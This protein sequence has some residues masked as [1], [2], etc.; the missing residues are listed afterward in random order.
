MAMGASSSLGAQLGQ[1]VR[2]SHILLILPFEN[3][4]SAPG[5]DWIGESFPEVIGNRM[6]A[7]PLFVISRD[8]RLYAFDRLGIPIGAKPSR[9]T[10]YE[11]AQQMDADYVVMG[12]YNFDGSTFSAHAQVMDMGKLRMS[13]ALS[14][15]GKLTDLI[16]IQ[17]ALTWDVLHSVG[18]AESI[19]RDE[20]QAQF[21]PI[22]L[23]ALE[24]YIRGVVAPN[25]QER[26][27]H[28]KEAIRLEPGH[29]LAMLQLGKTYYNARDYEQAVTWFSKVPQNDR[30]ANE[31]QFYLG[32]AA[33][34]TGQYEK[35]ESA[36]RFLTR[37]LPLTEVYNNLGVVAALRGDKHART[38]FERSTQTDPNDP[39]YHF[40]LAV[41]LCRQGDNTG[42]IREL[43]QLLSIRGDAE[44]RT[45]L[46]NLSS[47]S[48]PKDHLPLQR[49]KSNYDESSFRQ[50]AMEIENSNE[51]RLQ[52][53]DPVTHAA[54]R[55]QRGQQWLEQGLV[56]EAERDFREAVI[57]DPTNSEAHSGLARILEDAHD[58]KGARNEARVSLR[59]KPSAEAYLVLARLDLAEDDPQAAEQNVER[60]LALEPGNAA[61]TSLKSAIATALS[62]KSQ[63]QP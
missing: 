43:K 14:E 23:D 38:Y 63:L 22:R 16:R 30:N 28:F 19:S 18:M 50:I 26:I 44:A 29:T 37:R 55:V 34:Y 5:I 24:H 57:L 39:D 62:H 42:A 4:S 17:T 33:F 48:A 49:I 20:F 54:F 11:I 51:A 8:D 25:Q 27:K 46:D 40:N 3:V 15:S 36:F 61:A 21:S 6:A 7:M 31:A 58:S 13:P 60:A 59:L 47:G 32:M 53:T 1:P 2:S 52:K 41:E 45:F 35:A 9:A 12:R 10:V 56:S